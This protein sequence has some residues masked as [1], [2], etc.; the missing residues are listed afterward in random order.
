[1]WVLENMPKH[2]IK[3]TTETQCSIAPED[4]GDWEKDIRGG[5]LIMASRQVARALQGKTWTSS[6]DTVMSD[7]DHDA[8]VYLDFLRSSSNN[9]SR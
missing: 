7:D 3:L 8:H 9:P 6:A 1:M 4:F 2:N 5:V